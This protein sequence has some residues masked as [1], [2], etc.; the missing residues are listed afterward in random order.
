MMK[1]KNGRWKLYDGNKTVAE[2]NLA[3]V[4]RADYARKTAPKKKSKDSHNSHN[5]H[6]SH[7]Y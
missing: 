7:G 5:S 2:G 3:T 6:G 1:K 4:M